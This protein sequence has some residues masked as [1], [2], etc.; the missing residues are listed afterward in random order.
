MDKQVIHGTE[1]GP[2]CPF[3]R[4]WLAVHTWSCQEKRVARHLSVRNVEFFLPLYRR[5]SHWKNGL[6][7]P[8]ESP[9]FPGYI[10]VKIERKERFRIL[11]LAGTHS[12]VG[13]PHEPT[14]LPSAE[15][16]ML[17]ERI[18]LLGAEP[19]SYLNV[20]D[21]VNVR[22]GPLNGM[23]GI[24]VRRRNGCRLVVS[25][26]LIMKSIA[27]EVDERDLETAEPALEPLLSV[28]SEAA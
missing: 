12:I 22:S 13:T 1:T 7:V 16:E 19:H 25:L 28:A 15:I 5:I 23:S 18:H 14:P 21:R 6:R 24:V 26:A 4:E 17:R 20:G 10:F 27:V 11:E 2:L 3:S 8:I 9:L